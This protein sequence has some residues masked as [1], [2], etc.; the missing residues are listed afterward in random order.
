MKLSKI[1]L[2]TIIGASLNSS[3][4]NENKVNENPETKSKDSLEQKIDSTK[5][6]KIEIQNDADY[7]PP[8]GKG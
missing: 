6:S 3:C 4:K 5:N 8:C 2:S 7:C 1:L